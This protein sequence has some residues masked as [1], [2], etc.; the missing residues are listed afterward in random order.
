MI[1]I[2][3]RITNINFLRAYF[4]FLK[5]DGYLEHLATNTYENV[6]IYPDEH[7]K[8]LYVVPTDKN[9]VNVH[10]KPRDIWYLCQEV[11]K[12]DTNCI[13]RL[14]KAQEEPKQLERER[15]ER[16]MITM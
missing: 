10:K 6:N 13:S 15:E 12:Q 11:R 5:L 4:F 7:I 2:Y 16:K 9:S 3:Q 1:E 8:H 14:K